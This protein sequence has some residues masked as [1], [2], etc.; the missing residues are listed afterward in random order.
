MTDLGNLQ[1]DW[2]LGDSQKGEKV[3]EDAC[4]GCHGADG[5]GGVG[6]KLK[7][8]EFIQKSTNAEVLHLLFTGREGTAMR[9]FKGQLTEA[10]LA[11]V[12]VFLRTWQQ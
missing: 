12:I 1:R 10:Q 3:Y 2:P 5:Q 9:S 7:P 6:R 11:D 8:N 4:A